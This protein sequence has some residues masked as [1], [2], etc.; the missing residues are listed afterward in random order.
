MFGLLGAS[1][2]AHGNEKRYG[3]WDKALEMDILHDKLEAERMRQEITEQEAVE[4]RWVDGDDDAIQ[5]FEEQHQKNVDKY[6]E[7]PVLGELY[8]LKHYGPGLGLTGDWRKVG[9]F[10]SL[11]RRISLTCQR[12]HSSH[13]SP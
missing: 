4:Q 6:R 7:Q 2:A 10:F 11:T 13:I 1:P 8:P 9:L 3:G 12:A 5:A